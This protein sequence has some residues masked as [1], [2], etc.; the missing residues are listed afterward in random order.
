MGEAQRHGHEFS[1]FPRSITEHHSLVT[2]TLIQMKTFVIIHT[3]CDISTLLVNRRQ[4]SAR[5]AIEA[6][7]WIHITN[8]ANDFGDFALLNAAKGATLTGD[9]M[10]VLDVSSYSQGYGDDFVNQRQ[11]MLRFCVQ[12]GMLRWWRCSWWWRW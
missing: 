6:K 8:V 9:C 5:I 10:G 3:L 2:S 7:R 1:C 4:H 11:V 12:G